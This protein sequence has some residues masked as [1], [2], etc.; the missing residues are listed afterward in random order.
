MGPNSIDLKIIDKNNNDANFVIDYFVVNDGRFIFSANFNNMELEFNY[1]EFLDNSGDFDL[2]I[3]DQRTRPGSFFN[4]IEKRNTTLN[5]ISNLDVRVHK[6]NKYKL[7]ISFEVLDTENI[8]MSNY[9][10]SLKSFRRD[11]KLKVLGI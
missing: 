7:E 6:N 9:T 2:A 3:L 10:K 8:D 5:F 4:A 11:C 1:F